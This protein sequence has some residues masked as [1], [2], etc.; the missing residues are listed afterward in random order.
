MNK[1]ITIS[2]DENNSNKIEDIKI[3]RV[4]DTIDSLEAN[5]V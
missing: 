3:S 2:A 4:I 1:L 5:N